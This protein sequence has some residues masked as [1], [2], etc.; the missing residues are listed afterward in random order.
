MTAQARDTPAG[1]GACTGRVAS[2]N[3]CA[4][5]PPVSC[6]LAGSCRPVGTGSAKA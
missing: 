5:G 4:F 3:A 2:S 1:D 6:R